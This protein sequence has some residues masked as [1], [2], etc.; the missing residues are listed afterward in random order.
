MVTHTDEMCNSYLTE[1]YHLIGAKVVEF[2][3]AASLFPQVDATKNAI[4][5]V[6][7]NTARGSGWVRVG[8]A[9]VACKQ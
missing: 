8:I 5:I 9:V 4:V 1:A 2:F 6:Q 3:H 7:S